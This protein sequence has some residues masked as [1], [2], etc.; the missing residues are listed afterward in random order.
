[1]ATRLPTLMIR[2]RVVA[3]YPFAYFDSTFE[4]FDMIIVARVVESSGCKFRRVH[5][6]Q[7]PVGVALQSHRFQAVICPWKL[8]IIHFVGRDVIVG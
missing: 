8:G 6:A 5:E 3:L 2:H 1:M 4:A 7:R